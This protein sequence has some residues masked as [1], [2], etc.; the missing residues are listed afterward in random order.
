MGQHDRTGR[1]PY[2]LYEGYGAGGL[3]SEHVA[4]A[5]RLSANDTSFWQRYGRPLVP[6]LVLLVVIALLWE[7]AKV[8]FAIPDNK[9]PH[10]T[11]IFREFGERTQGGSG[12]IW[13]ELMLSNGLAT[14]GV[15]VL[16]FLIGTVLGCL[17]AVVFA[18]SELL[19]RGCLPYVVGSQLVPLLAIA[20]M[21][22]IG[23]GRLGAPPFL[24][25]SLIAAYLTFFPVTVGMLRGLR[26]VSPDSLAL[27]RSYAASPTQTFWKLRLPAALPFLFTS[28][29]IAASASVIGAIVGEL[30]S[31][32]PIGVGPMIIVAAQYY[33]SRP[34]NL[35]A[36]VFV[37][38][39]IGLI[40]SG[41]VAGIERLVVPKR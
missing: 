19:S 12:P 34:A 4:T 23:I 39:V 40:F 21:V 31:G 38:A 8:L 27:M 35:W 1:L 25:K 6:P 30:P 7:S 32:S 9:L 3:L 5:T 36:A 26:S 20:P 33:T 18:R 10:L 29:K 37:S 15:A 22:V 17:L 13:A 2:L 14:F 28:L 41:I 24:A 16:G 11:S